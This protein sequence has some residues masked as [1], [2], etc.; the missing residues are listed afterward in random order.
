MFVYRDLHVV[1]ESNI[2]SK[3]QIEEVSV[4][5]FKISRFVDVSTRVIVEDFNKS[6]FYLLGIIS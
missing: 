3:T 5:L 6:K 1:Q 4:H 2:A